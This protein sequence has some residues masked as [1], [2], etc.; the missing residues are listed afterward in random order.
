MQRNDSVYAKFLVV[1]I[2]IVLVH[3]KFDIESIL[4]QGSGAWP[5]AGLGLLKVKGKFNSKSNGTYTAYICKHSACLHTQK[6]AHNLVIQIT[7][8]LHSK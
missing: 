6:Y 7:L 3:S 8:K 5:C 4:L 2:Q 1:F